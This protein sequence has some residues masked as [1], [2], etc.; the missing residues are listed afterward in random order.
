MGSAKSRAFSQHDQVDAE[1]G[2]PYGDVTDLII[3]MI[4]FAGII[5]RVQLI[6][7]CQF[8]TA[9][10]FLDIIDEDMTEADCAA[11]LLYFHR[12]LTLN[13]TDL[14]RR[15]STGCNAIGG[16]IPERNELH[17]RRQDLRTLP[18]H[19]AEKIVASDKGFGIWIRVMKAVFR[20]L[21]KLPT[22][23][24]NEKL[25]DAIPYLSWGQFESAFRELTIWHVNGKQLKPGNFTDFKGIWNSPTG[26]RTAMKVGTMVGQERVERRTQS[27]CLFDFF[28]LHCV[29]VRGGKGHHNC[30]FIG[31]NMLMVYNFTA[32]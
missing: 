19:E 21:I 13:L 12:F 2:D 14:T 6:L 31:K 17:G 32:F 1:T 27:T 8:H 11:T 16:E 7:H 18:A 30:I 20:K 29:D 28:Q 23:C 10:P 25:S 26:P 3:G 4:N 24:A 5:E 9:L 15:T 22:G